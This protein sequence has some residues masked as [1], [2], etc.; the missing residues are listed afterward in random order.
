MKK[1]QPTLFLR[2]DESDIIKSAQFISKN[3]DTDPD[4]IFGIIRKWKDN[5]I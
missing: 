5:F 3:T 1:S 4:M 2:Y